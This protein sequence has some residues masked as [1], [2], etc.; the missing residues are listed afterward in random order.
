M[1]KRNRMGIMLAVLIVAAAGYL[2]FFRQCNILLQVDGELPCVEIRMAQSENQVR[3]WF[4]E[5][6]EKGYFFLPSC[7]KNYQVSL[8]D[9]G[10]N[11]VRIDGD[12]YREGDVFTWEEGCSYELQVTDPSYQSV[13]YEIAFLKSANIPAMFIATESGG[14]E[15]LHED[16]ENEE[17]GNLCVVRADGTAEYQGELLRISGRGNSTW[18]Y[19]KKPYALKL[20]K[21]YPLCGLN[22]GDRWRLLALWNEGSKLD[23][24]IAMDLAQE[25]GLAY[26]MQGTWVDLY[27][28]GEYRGIYLLTESVTVGEG[29][30]NIYDLDKENKRRNASIAQGTAERYEEENNKGYVLENG[31]D[32]SGGYLIEKD[33]PEHYVAEENGFVT[34]R[35]DPFTINAPR[36]ASREQVAYIQNCVE[37]IDQLIQSGDPE[38]WEKMDLVSFTDR[39]LVDEIAMEKDAGSTS[40]FFYKDRGDEKL[41]SGPAWDYDRAFGEDGG[42]DGIYTNYTETNVNN[43]ERLAIALNWYQKLY[44]MP[45]FQRCIAEK[46]AKTLPFFEKLLHTG[47]DSYADQIRAS[48]AMDDARWESV[49]QFGEDGTS[50]Y[51]NYD[52]NVSYTKYFLANRLNYLCE[53]WGVPHDAFAA[54]ASGEVHRLTFSVYEGVVETIEVMDGEPLSYTPD[55]DG[56]V[57]Q[58][59]SIKRT[60]ESVNSYIPVYEDMELYNAKWG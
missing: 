59:W 43:N 2:Y 12:L 14:L 9:T 3:M 27:L 58:G 44:D 49:R 32:I 7:V 33:H 52:A 57:Y 42:S 11:S 31:E 26:S 15:Y 28:N 48:V 41:Y 8:G 30:V 18:E 54:P 38:V 24:K 29:R 16:K 55:Y 1:R 5:E 19:E 53:R 50:R 25:L 60:G 13:T 36:H 40:M 46:Y 22:K 23:D 21:A 45:E 35:G 20:P 10:E 37:T 6:T 51:Q 47:I 56:N 39:F 17:P 4:S 34:S